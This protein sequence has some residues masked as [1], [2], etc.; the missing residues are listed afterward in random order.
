MEVYACSLFVNLK[1]QQ[2]LC[3]ISPNYHNN[4]KTYAGK[5]HHIEP[6]TNF[7]WGLMCSQFAN[8]GLEVQVLLIIHMLLNKNIIMSLTKPH[9]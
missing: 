5:L 3:Y 4:F 7:V 8:I 6:H 1:R 9:I 2:M